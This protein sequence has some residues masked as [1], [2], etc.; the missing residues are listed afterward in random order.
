MA[1]SRPPFRA[2]HVGSLLRPPALKALRLRVASGHASAAELSAA[3][4]L[5]IREVVRLQEEIGLQ[6]IT[7]G[8]LRRGSWHMDFLMQLGGLSS[9]G[10]RIPVTFHGRDGEVFFTRPDLAITSRVTR[11]RPIFVPAFRFL[12]SVVSRTPKLTMPSPSMLYTQVGRSNISPAVYSDLDGFVEDAAAAYRGEISDLYAAVFWSASPHA[13]AAVV[14]AGSGTRLLAMLGA[15]SPWAVKMAG[16]RI[17]PPPR[18]R[19]S[20]R[21]DIGLPLELVPRVAGR[22]RPSDDAE[23]GTARSGQSI[24]R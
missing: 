7:D 21:L 23:R 18:R 24:Q 12:A 10:Q 19:W 13:H 4:D 6:G 11:P 17:P 22:T 1:T 8:E 3:E 9:A 16:A 2:D 5:A 14:R 20:R 15:R